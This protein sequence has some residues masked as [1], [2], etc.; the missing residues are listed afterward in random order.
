MILFSNYAL[1]LKVQKNAR[2]LVQLYH[3]QDYYIILVTAVKLLNTQLLFY[4]MFLNIYILHNFI[5][6]FLWNSKYALG[7]IKSVKERTSLLRY[8]GSC[9]KTF[10]N[11]AA[12]LSDFLKHSYI[13]QFY[14]HFPMI[15]L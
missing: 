1:G 9:G 6:S 4:Q 8:T 13:T 5:C 2:K 12:I 15:R 7:L 11:S 10:N 3:I 14:M